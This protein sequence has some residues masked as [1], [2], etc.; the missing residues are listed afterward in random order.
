[1]QADGAAI[2]I[3]HLNHP[4]AL[5]SSL[6]LNVSW[7]VA[8]GANVAY[9]QFPS[10]HQIFYPLTSSSSSSSTMSYNLKNLWYDPIFHVETLD[11]QHVW[12]THHYHIRAQS[13]AGNFCFSVLD[14]GITSDEYWSIVGGTNDLLWVC[15]HYA[16]ATKVVGQ[17]YISGL[18]CTVTGALPPTKQ[19]PVIQ[20]C[21]QLVGIELWELMVVNNDCSNPGYV[22]AGL[23]LLDKYQSKIATISATA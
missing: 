20:Q 23:L 21:L 7:M 4:I 22:A 3:G 18:V 14:N 16:S 1:M 17:Q 9:N 15:F 12:C 8:C 5:A 13:Q 6:G 2:L 19:W 11:G 10:Q